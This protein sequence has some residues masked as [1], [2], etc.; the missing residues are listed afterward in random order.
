MTTTGGGL[1]RTREARRPPGRS[2]DLARRPLGTGRS[3]GKES[4][5]GQLGSDPDEAPADLE[6]WTTRVEAQLFERA[7]G[8]TKRRFSS[9]FAAQIARTR[10]RFAVL[11]RQWLSARLERTFGTPL[12]AHLPPSSYAALAGERRES[13]TMTKVRSAR[14]TA[15]R[16]C[17][18]CRRTKRPCGCGY[19]RHLATHS[20]AGP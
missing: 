11:S 5:P 4:G 2:Q 1:G 3:R 12:P 13:A 18:S 9:R 7:A 20:D 6:A 8:A 10:F 15:D 19:L 14:S 17:G 16:R